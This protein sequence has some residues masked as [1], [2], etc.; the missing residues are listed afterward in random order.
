LL[1]CAV[2]DNLKKICTERH[3]FSKQQFQYCLKNVKQIKILPLVPLF[4]DCDMQPL[5]GEVFDIF[6]SLE[7]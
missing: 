3:I 1:F 7:M 6:E 5:V 2:P 4:N